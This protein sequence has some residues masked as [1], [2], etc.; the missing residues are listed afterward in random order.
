MY[1]ECM[2]G[3][4]ED[5]VS[6]QRRLGSIWNVSLLEETLKITRTDGITGKEDFERIM[7]PKGKLLWKKYSENTE[8]MDMVCY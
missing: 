7:W 1:M 5:N 6:E 8:W 4:P 2:G 3:R